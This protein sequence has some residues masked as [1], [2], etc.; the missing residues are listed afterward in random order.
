MPW[1]NWFALIIIAIL[2]YLF[3][4]NAKN[5]ATVIGALSSGANSSIA[6]LQGRGNAGNAGTQVASITTPQIG[7]FLS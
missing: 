5:T 7:S 2:A 4:N 6:T 1:H 3:L